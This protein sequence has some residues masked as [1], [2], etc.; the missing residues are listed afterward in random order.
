MTHEILNHF[1]T[2]GKCDPKSSTMAYALMKREHITLCDMIDA[3]E[4][5]DMR[6]VCPIFDGAIVT[7]KT[8]EK[9]AA[10]TE[11]VKAMAAYCS[12]KCSVNLLIK[13][14]PKSQEEERR[15]NR[16]KMEISQD[17]T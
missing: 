6:L 13:P 4:I 11:G 1:T 14:W 17:Q 10:V 3:L 15:V 9:S 7:H 2:L 12:T 16:A 5:F 8:F